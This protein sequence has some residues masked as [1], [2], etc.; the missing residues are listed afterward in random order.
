MF[1]RR[2]DTFSTIHIEGSVLPADLLQRID[3]GDRGLGGLDPDAYHL[4][5]G[6]KLNE[7]INRSWNRLCG[8]WTTFRAHATRI[9]ENDLG[10]T[11][12]RERWLL[13]LFHEL[14]Y[15][16]LPTAR[17]IELED[18]SYPISHAWQ[19]TPMHLVGYRVDLD[20]RQSGVAGAAR[21]SPHGLVQELLNHSDA[22]LWAF[23]SNGL[24]L[25][26]LRDNSSLTRQAYVEFDLEA[27]MEGEVYADFVLLWLLCHQ[28]RVEA[29]P[30]PERGEGRE[31][32]LEKWSR[33]AQEQGVRFLD[34]LR[35]G[36]E[37]AIAAFGRGFLSHPANHVLKDKLRAGDLS[38]E[39]YY[40]Q[41]LRLVYRLLF[42]FVAEDRGLLLDPN[43]ETTARDRYTRYYSMARLRA[44][45]ER[46]RGTRHADLYHG[47]RLVMLKLGEDGGC[48]E[49][50]LPALGSFLFGH[51]ATPDL[52][53]SEI[54]NRD[55]LE[56]IRALSS[57]T[58]GH[59]LRRVDYKNL[60]PEELGSVYESLLELHPEFNVDASTFDLKTA[61]GN[62]RK[63]SGSYYTP[64]SLVQCLLDSALD[65]VLDEAARKENPEKAILSLKVCDPACGSGH[66]LIAAAHRLARR[67][68][69]V[70]TGEDEPSPKAI[71]GA[72]HDVI[73][74]CVYGV[75]INPM[76]VELCKVNLWVE[77]LEPGKPLSFLDHHIQCGNSL[78]GATPALLDGGIP[79]EAFSPIE[80]D[81]RA[82][83]AEYKRRNR[84]ERNGQRSLFNRDALQPWD[85]LGDLAGAI[86]DL[87][88]VPDDTL[89]G[90]RR[91]QELYEKLV[92]SDA[93]ENGR[94]R[95]DTWCAAFV[96]KKTKETWPITEEEYRHVERNPHSLTPW[97]REEIVR[98][99]HQYQFLHWHLAFPDVLCV[100]VKD[101]EP[102]NEQTGWRGGFDVVLGNPPWERTNLQEREW[103][104]TRRPDIAD[105]PNAARR[106]SMIQQLAAED[107]TLYGQFRAAHRQAEGEGHLIRNSGRYPLCCKGDVNTYAIF[108]ET[109]RGLLSHDG[110]AG[111]VIQSEIATGDT[112]KEFFGDLLD[113]R[114]LVSFYDFVNTEGLFP[115]IHRTHPHFCLLTLS[116]RPISAAA[117]FAFWN[118]RPSHLAEPG[119]HFLM[120]ADDFRLINPNT[121]TCAVFRSGR[122]ADI[123]KAVYRR[124]PVLV[125][126]LGPNGNPW[127]IRMA[128]ML[129]MADDSHLF[130]SRDQLEAEGWRLDGGIFRRGDRIYV[131]LYEATLLH[132]FDHRWATYEGNETRDPYPH[133]KSDP[134]YVVLP[135]YWVPEAEVNAYLADKPSR[136][137]LLGWRDITNTTNE[138]TVITAALP[139]SACGDTV[140]LMFPEVGGNGKAGLLIASMNSYILD[141]SA[142]QKIGGTH[143]KQHVFKQLP[144]I[145]PIAYARRCPW[146]WSD[147][148]GTWLIPHAL[149]L[150]YTAWDL[151]PFARD[152]G[153]D[154][155]PFRWDEDKRFLLRCEL[156]AVYFHLYG[157]ARDD[158]EYIMETFPILKRKDETKH[159]EYRTKRVIL[160]IY[161]EMA[162]VMADNVAAE[163]TGRQPIA[164]YE[165]RLNPLP[166][167]PTDAGGNF[168]PMEKWDR[169]NWPSHIH[170][171]KKEAVEGPEEV[172]WEEFAAMTYPATDADRAICAA[173]LAI[174][175]QSGTISSAD[176]LDALLLATH[177]EWCKEFLNESEHRAFDTVRNRALSTLF[178]GGEQAIHWLDCRDY[179]EQQRA[180]YVNR[181]DAL[182][183]LS[184]GANLKSV[185]DR[186]PDRMDEIVHF[187]I[188]AI[189]RIGELR[190]DPASITQRHAAII[191]LFEEQHRLC[192]LS[193]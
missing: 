161:D 148:L 105:A 130:R 65:P 104:A 44:L 122:D 78:L 16:R 18:K 29:D 68:A 158:V 184:P 48:A 178:A 57:T 30:S 64:E 81:D 86:V 131:P 167:P 173:A 21:L 155:P 55:L 95:A 116:G 144:V 102:G 165:T 106:R 39:D 11:V 63:T 111:F 135:R 49:L 46:R 17:A 177:P 189:R 176:H 94:L 69:A 141:Y 117:D 180:I 1:V 99:R 100:P 75:D 119:R 137:W 125:S 143:L 19:N 128:R 70:R 72:L 37:E 110:R 133:E 31:C 47:L 34:Q 53:S 10:T 92:R 166:G 76:A 15:G 97:R 45:A 160:E 79:D 120:T 101:E 23:V 35:S 93:Y 5:A 77:A 123:A 2:R 67:L 172:P 182:Q 58:D 62:E 61:G 66:F 169:A 170:L 33:A 36:V 124:V 43:S 40:R 121:R 175:E 187:A 52:E 103:F 26:I 9:P 84:Q 108:A 151:R 109:N 82:V 24:Q 83:C 98:L 7:A 142:R 38:R 132:Q 139:R 89:E 153:Y 85:R 154:G 3:V 71:R 107:P 91:R 127:N 140:T 163:S 190:K 113:S 186:L 20:R 146:S 150:I 96:W 22:H 159:G 156:D 134:S 138:R 6:V 25:R 112:Y 32:W 183:T 114:E 118:T 115:G 181:G 188:G 185:R 152:M 90:I 73:G 174:A 14:S 171:P 168:V 54:A 13:P 51:D 88:A 12:T 74:R 126:E 60:G 42:L 27:M 136:H 162:R 164:R 193:A 56:A 191:R 80:G 129:H 147:Q 4:D 41:L 149:E 59:T 145:P 157:I 192:R 87:D 28:S 50:G 8:V 179:L